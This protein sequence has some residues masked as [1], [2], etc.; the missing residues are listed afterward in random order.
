MKIL[1][2]EDEALIAMML[3]TQ[4][5]EKGHIVL[6]PVST[7]EDVIA[8][9]LKEKPDLIIM[10][11]VL[12]GVTNGI[13]AAEIINKEFPIPVVFTTGYEEIQDRELSFQPLA[14]LTKPIL[15]NMLEEI[16]KRVKIG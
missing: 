13:E 7:G 8:L 3:K 5:E 12:A 14:Y 6:G 2:A 15:P 9:A 4:L 1:I 11:V 10:D 16:L